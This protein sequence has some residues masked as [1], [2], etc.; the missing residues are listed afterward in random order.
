MI[1]KC[2]KCKKSMVFTNYNLTGNNLKKIFVCKECNTKKMV[3]AVEDK[4]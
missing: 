2:H 4:K 3:K 1:P